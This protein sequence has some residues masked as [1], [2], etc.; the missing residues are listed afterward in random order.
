MRIGLAGWAINRRFRA[1][2]EKLS[3]LDFPRIAREEFDIGVIELNNPFFTSFEDDYL[4]ELAAN[5]KAYD[6]EME[7]MAVDNTG[8]L[9]LLDPEQRET[10]ITNAMAYF[11]IAEKLGLRY[12]RVNTGG[13]ADG[14][15]EMLAACVDSFRRLAEEGKKRGISIA[16]ENHGGLSTDPRMMVRLITG[17]NMPTMTTLPDFG[18][19]PEDIVLSGMAQILPYA[20]A[21]HV[22]WTKR[23]AQRNTASG[24]RD[25][26][27]F[28]KVCRQSGFDG[29]L[30]IEDGG[31]D[32]DH[33]GVLELKGAVLA[34]LNS[35][36]V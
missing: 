17:V 2:G 28:V 33:R 23:D 7:G 16:T 3:M 19:F 15:P 27:A 29:T 25:V 34:A 12:F 26:P 18:N 24:R 20:A 1:E 6:V 4:A 5:A 22:K 31:P 11:D 8:D 10:S 30:F 35:E 32:C 13:S 21:A 14:P 9:S 36:L